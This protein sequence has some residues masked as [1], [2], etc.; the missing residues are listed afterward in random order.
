LPASAETVALYIRA[1]A[2]R[3]KPS[4]LEHHLAAIGKAHKA[5]GFACPMTYNILVAETLKGIKR[6][7]GTAALQKTPVLSKIS[8]SLFACHTMICKEF[9]TE[10]CSLS[11]SR[12]HFG[13][14]SW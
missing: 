4:T 3:L 8:A 2:E 14:G 12:E 13:V 11:A 7:H 5:A 6:T 9:E 1:G 10:H